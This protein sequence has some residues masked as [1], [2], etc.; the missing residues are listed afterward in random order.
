MLDTRPLQNLLSRYGPRI[1]TASGELG[2]SAAN[3]QIWTPGSD[4]PAAPGGGGSGL[5]TPGQPAPAPAAQA[6]AAD[7]PR[8]IIPGR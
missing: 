3:P 2:I 4:A 8:L 7:K 1:T 6:P 5:W